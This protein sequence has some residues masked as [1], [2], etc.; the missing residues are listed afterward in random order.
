MTE[1]EQYLRSYMGVADEDMAAIVSF[2]R[3]VTLDKGDYFLKAGRF[4]EKLSFQ[5]SGLMRV[6]ASHA[7]KEVTQWISFK[8]SLITDLNS[9]I[10]NEPSRYNIQA[11]AACELYSIDKKDY[12]G[13]AEVIPKWPALERMLIASFAGPPAR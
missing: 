8:G 1:L 13:L 9:L 10:C 6:F 7:E 5:R 4:C 11:L 12:L 3:P 2:F